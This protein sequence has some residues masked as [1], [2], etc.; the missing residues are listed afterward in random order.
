MT[1]LEEYPL[2]RP[3]LNLILLK[4]PIKETSLVI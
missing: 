4:K 2:N 3:L 1:L